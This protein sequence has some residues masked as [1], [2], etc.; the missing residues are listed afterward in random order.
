MAVLVCF[1]IAL[2]SCRHS[3]INESD[4]K[5]IGGRVEL[6]RNWMVSLALDGNSHICAGTL[7][8]KQFILTAAHC[9][10]DP[11]RGKLWVASI[12]AWRFDVTGKP[13]APIE[14]IPV[15]LIYTHELYDPNTNQNDIA[16]VLLEQASAQ[17]VVPLADGE[18]KE[19]QFRVMG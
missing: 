13:F 18:D 19:A 6:A 7:I 17:A 9:F 15:K 5:I 8:D 4:V 2:C 3:N 1:E 10:Q 12:G 11:D 14:Q 16:L